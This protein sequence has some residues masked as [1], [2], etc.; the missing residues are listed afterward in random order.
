MK[1]LHHPEL[2]KT[3]RASTTDH[4]ARVL[5]L[6]S[7]PALPFALVANKHFNSPQV[8]MR[9]LNQGGLGGCIADDPYV[10]G[11]RLFIYLPR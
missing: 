5:F 10:R 3:R 6:I 1:S 7:Q 11:I 4:Q 8:P 9:E 2:R